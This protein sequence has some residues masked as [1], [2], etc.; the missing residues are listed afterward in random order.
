MSIKYA[1]I[2]SKLA[3]TATGYVGHIRHDKTIQFDQLVDRVAHS[4]TTVSRSDVLSVLEDF[5]TAVID[6][7][8][9]GK[10]V[11][12]PLAIFKA[13]LRGT[14]ENV[15]DNYDPSRHCVIARLRPGSRLRQAMRQ[16]RM[17]KVDPVQP[18]PLPRTYIDGA[19]GIQD[20][21]LTPGGPGQLLG[22][23]LQHD[24]Q[25]PAQGIFFCDPHGVAVRVEK[26][27]VNEQVRLAFIVPALPPGT[28]KVQVRANVNGTGEIRTGEMGTELTVS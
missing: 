11:C 2:N 17:E 16:A 24:P 3:H 12:T 27:V 18:I 7:V 4:N 15:G 21:V 8:L 14:F 13:G 1:I 5:I 6:M 23:R 22:R 10:S 26:L 19:S 28:Y 20:K 25:D 9:D